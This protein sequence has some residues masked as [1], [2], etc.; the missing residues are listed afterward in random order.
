MNVGLHSAQSVSEKFFTNDHHHRAHEI[1]AHRLL[2]D[3]GDAMGGSWPVSSGGNFLLLTL[4]VQRLKRGQA[5]TAR[6]QLL[7]AT[8]VLLG[9]CAT[10]GPPPP[11]PK[12]PP[13]ASLQELMQAAEAS[14]KDGRREAARLQYRD[15]AK[16]YPTNALPWTKLAEDYFAAEDHGNAILAAQEV[17]LREPQNVVAQSVLAVS[18]LRVSSAALTSLRAQQSGVPSSTREQAALLT[19]TLRE[20][21]GESVLVPRVNSA[22]SESATSTPSTTASSSAGQAPARGKPTASTKPKSTKTPAAPPAV[23]APAAATTSS[24]PFDKLK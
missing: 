18:G 1:N 2:R 11:P 5:A 7:A 14:A 24:N 10:S 16:A 20:A 4:I 22:G 21:L 6:W 8:A 9:A 13:Q 3:R 15:A 23:Q 17:V 19:K 12:A